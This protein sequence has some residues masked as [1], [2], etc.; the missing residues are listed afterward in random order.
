MRQLFLVS[1]ALLA[2]L[3]LGQAPADQPAAKRLAFDVASVKPAGRLDPQKIMSGQQR[4]GLESDNARVTISSMTLNDLIL[5]AFKIKSYQVSGP[6]WLSSGLGADR[7]EVRATI[8][9]G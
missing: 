7:F 2:S 9:E 4:I 3:A 5:I 8:P 6:S 1:I